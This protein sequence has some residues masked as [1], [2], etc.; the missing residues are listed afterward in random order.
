MAAAAAVC[1]NAGT[2]WNTSAAAMVVK[3][4]SLMVAV[5]L[6]S[7]KDRDRLTKGKAESL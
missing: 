1:V 5:F 7:P 4:L 3:M 2:A 6:F